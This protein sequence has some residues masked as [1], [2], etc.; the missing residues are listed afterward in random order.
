MQKWMLL[1]ACALLMSALHAQAEEDIYFTNNEDRYYHLDEGCDR[2]PDMELETSHQSIHPLQREIYRKYPI[3]EAAALE[4]GKAACPVCISGFEPLYLGDKHPVWNYDFEPWAFGDMEAG[5]LLESFLP[6]QTAD[7]RKEYDEAI[8][9][10]LEAD[11][12]IV[13]VHHWDEGSPYPA[14]YVGRESNNMHTATFYFTSIETETIEKLKKSFNYVWV[15]PG[16]YAFNE[17]YQYWHAANEKLAAW[18]EEN[19]M[20]ASMQLMFLPEQSA[21]FIGFSGRN[22]QEA[23]ELLEKDAP[24]FVHF[25][26]IEEKE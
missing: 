26:V 25:A 24:I 16:K 7:F 18:R 13:D 1:L 17:M 15:A 4:F 3:S 6:A 19:D 8:V 5:E 14:S 12:W 23:V 9:H 11:T 22:A 21:M 20:E 2:F 10:L